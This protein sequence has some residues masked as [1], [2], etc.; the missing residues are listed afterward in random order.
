METMTT[1]TATETATSGLRASDVKAFLRLAREIR[2]NGIYAQ[3][4]ALFAFRRSDSLTIWLGHR[5]DI[6]PFHKVDASIIER[7]LEGAEFMRIGIDSMLIGSKR[8][9]LPESDG[10]APRSLGGLIEIIDEPDLGTLCACAM[11]ENEGWHDKFRAIRLG[12]ALSSDVATNGRILHARIGIARVI[13]RNVHLSADWPGL[14]DATT[15]ELHENGACWKW[16]PFRAQ[17]LYRPDEFPE[18]RRLFERIPAF[19]AKW[20]WSTEHVASLAHVVHDIAERDAIVRGEIVPVVVLKSDGERLTMSAGG[21]VLASAQTTHPEFTT[22][23][24][25]DQLLR[26]MSGDWIREFAVLSAET[27]VQLFGANARGLAMPVLRNWL[28]NT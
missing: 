28:K 14:A 18:W 22:Y 1:T 24:D 21:T 5:V 12:R 6:H 23:L 13:S 4:N 11:K 3:S 16:G 9:P 19:L 2:A 10:W 27:P 15:L 8:I 20:P 17:A 25:I 26:L 7:A